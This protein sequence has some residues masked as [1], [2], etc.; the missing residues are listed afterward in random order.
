MYTF[1]M[2]AQPRR[3]YNWPIEATLEVIGGKWKTSILWHLR[4][5]VR[6][7]SELKRLMPKITQRM[8]TQQ[9]RMLESNGIVARKVYPVV[10]P[11]VEYSLTP[12]GKS[13]RP[14]LDQMCAWGE[15]RL[16]NLPGTR[17]LKV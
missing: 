10:P 13:L 16:R 14:I 5:D 1:E 4:S 9:L 8:L 2:K 6:R 17:L 7:F 3:T 12:L 15:K 11:K